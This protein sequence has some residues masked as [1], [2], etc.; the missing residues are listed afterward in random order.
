MKRVILH[1]KEIFIILSLSTAVSAQTGAGGTES[2]FIYG[3]HARTLG[4][5]NAAVAYPSGSGAIYWNPAGMQM[6]QQKSVDLSLST[7]F[8][9]THY[10]YAGYIH[11]SLK[12]GTFGFGLAIIGTGGVM[13]REWESNIISNLGEM[14][15]W[16]GKFS[17]AYSLQLFN[18]FSAGVSFE[19]NR[20]VLGEWAANG[21]GF[22]GGLHY[23]FP[24]EQG[25]LKDLHLGMSVDN[26]ISPRLRMG[27]ETEI[28]PYII[29]VGLAKRFTSR[30]AAHALLFLVD[31]EKS[32]FRDTRL[33]LG[34]EYAVGRAF[35]LRTGL[36]A[37]LIT[38]GGGIR[39][40]DLQIDYGAGPLANMDFLPWGHRFS[41]RFLIGKSLPE[42]REEI[43]LAKQAE[44]QRR[45]MAR[46]ASEKETRIADGL[47]AAREFLDKAEY[48]DA[49]I[50]LSQV[51]RDD[52]EN[53]EAL[54]LLDLVETREIDFQEN[55]RLELLKKDRD[56]IK[57]ENELK[58]ISE[59]R[60]KANKALADG[61]FR[62]A[63]EFLDEA[64]V[65]DPENKQLQTYKQQSESRLKQ[66]IA[67][68]VT[69]AK[70]LI[71]QEAISEAYK[72]LDIAKNQ[73]RGY[74]VLLARV[75][76]ERL[77]LDKEVDFIHNY[78]EG[79]KRYNRKDY[80]GALP[81]LNRA[82]RM[83]PDHSRVREMVSISSSKVSGKDQPLTGRAKQLYLQGI[84]LYK[85]GKVK[86]AIKVWEE[87]LDLLPNSGKLLKTLNSVRSS[88]IEKR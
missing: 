1:L 38:F 15:Y 88:Y 76:Q 22:N 84:N 3:L 6:V 62:K 54:Q 63:V 87:A 13:Q 49:R 23:S 36:N 31:V 39:Y 79:R 66:E 57:H 47:N 71:K 4:M 64:L 55:R 26:I 16:W 74:S 78:Q 61:D 41:L 56:R 5:G 75:A 80:Q 72:A 65:K 77:K 19:A 35:F 46:M 81:F 86:E 27:T 44:I 28:L 37:G 45:L 48:F 60:L 24:Q 29:R 58:F 59:K 40:K 10:N 8:A 14:D 2:P 33:H 52:K 7:L 69:R 25:L 21:F 85:V 73:A 68:Q 34:M 53:K 83:K 11:P 12:S 32:K 50:E 20:K 43:E 70:H 30:N 67:D 9:G 18:G 42:K 51:L 17:L 82:L